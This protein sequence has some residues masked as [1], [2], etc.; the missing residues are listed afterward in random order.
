[1]NVKKGTHSFYQWYL[2]WCPLTPFAPFV[3]CCFHHF[4]LVANLVNTRKQFSNWKALLKTTACCVALLC[5]LSWVLFEITH[6]FLF[7]AR[8]IATMIIVQTTI[9]SSIEFPFLT[10]NDIWGYMCLTSSSKLKQKTFFFLLN[11]NT[12][13]HCSFITFYLYFLVKSIV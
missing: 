9:P 8:I 6:Y 4:Y 10:M 5:S 13:Y 2:T 3:L 12:I 7:I 11:C 1:M